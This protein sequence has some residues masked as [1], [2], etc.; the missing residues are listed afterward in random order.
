MSQQSLECFLSNSILVFST[1]VDENDLI[2]RSVIALE[3]RGWDPATDFSNQTRDRN[4]PGAECFHSGWLIVGSRAEVTALQCLMR[5]R[6]PREADEPRRSPRFVP[7]SEWV[8]LYWEILS[9]PRRGGRLLLPERLRLRALLRWL[10]QAIE[11][12]FGTV[13]ETTMERELCL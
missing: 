10:R 8:W 11:K 6:I 9:T 7:V 13:T 2:V 3:S 12:D 1:V 5:L 4:K